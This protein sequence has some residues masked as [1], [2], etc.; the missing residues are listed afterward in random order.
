MAKCDICGINIPSIRGEVFCRDCKL[1]VKLQNKE[2]ILK[3][4]ETSGLD[5]LITKRFVHEPKPKESLRA[6]AHRKNIKIKENL[7]RYQTGLK[8]KS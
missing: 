1:K 7:C 5:H 8:K 3:N 6:W 2:I 4:L